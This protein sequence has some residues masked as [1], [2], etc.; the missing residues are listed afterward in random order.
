MKFIIRSLFRITV[1]ILL[2]LIVLINV[3]KDTNFK[4]KF[5]QLVYE[6]NFDFAYVNS[7]YKQY[8]GDAIPF[9]KM[10]VTKTVF[11]E[12]LVYDK[13]LPYLD[14]V[15]LSVIDDYLVPVLNS[16]LVV[17]IGEK[18]GYGQVVV[19]EQVDGVDCWYGNL[20]TVNVKL[21]DYVEDGS[22]LGSVSNKLYLVYKQNGEVISYEKYLS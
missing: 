10:L 11:S 15:E 19:I 14:G 1:T 6:D 21:Y 9:K 7:L 12:T 16:G 4:N 17:Y 22:L 8:F 3:K 20:D 18:E 2:T 5:Y 13:S